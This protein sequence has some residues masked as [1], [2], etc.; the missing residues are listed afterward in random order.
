MKKISPFRFFRGFTLMETLLAIALVGVL[1][2][3]FL[4]V[5]VPARGLVRQALTRQESERI[6][7]ILRAELSSLRQD[8]MAGANAKSSSENSYLS[9]FDK[10]FHWL[11]KTSRPSSAIVI[12][13]YRADLSKPAR[14]DGTYPAVPAG[15]SVPGKNMQL[16]SIACPMD[17]PIHRDDIRDAVGPVF[18]VKMTQLELKSNGEYRPVN[19]PG[20]ISRASSPEAYVSEPGSSD[21]WGGAIFCR[22]DFYHMSP[23][24]PARYKGKP[25][26]K[27][28]R[29]LFSANLSFH[30]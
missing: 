9:T 22:A 1:L 26:K 3:I 15:K 13:S 6:T 25:W 12:F 18:L 11:R 19:S 21:P 4:T 8:E 2:S 23:P 16:V 29:P 27:L 24:I 14:A 10:G 7:G 17:D 5:F 20:T 30:R 28:G